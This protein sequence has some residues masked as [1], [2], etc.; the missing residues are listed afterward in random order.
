VHNHTAQNHSERVLQKIRAVPVGGDMRSIT[1]TF[2][3]N[4][5]HYC[6]GYRRATKEEPSYTA[7][8]TRGM[9]SIHPEQDRFL[10]PRECARIQSFPDTFVFHGSTIENYTQVCNAVPPLLAEAIAQNI[11][12]QTAKTL[13]KRRTRSSRETVR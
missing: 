4:R 5:T 11:A 2:E 12:D 9:T 7:Y 1:P 8:W 13:C 10:T 6:G 3:E